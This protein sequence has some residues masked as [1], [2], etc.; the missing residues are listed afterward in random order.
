MMENYVGAELVFAW[1]GLLVISIAVLG[2]I[3]KM[4][5]FLI[6]GQMPR[7]QALIEQ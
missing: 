7:G 2:S 6:M 1:I 5:E 3:V 4:I